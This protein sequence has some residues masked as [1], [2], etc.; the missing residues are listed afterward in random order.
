MVSRLAA[1]LIR[2]VT[3]VVAPGSRA[4]L[5]RPDSLHYFRFADDTGVITWPLEEA[6]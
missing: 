4:T 6:T 3:V 1:V 2:F 5:K